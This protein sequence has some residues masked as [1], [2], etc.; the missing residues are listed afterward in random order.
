MTLTKAQRDNIL[1]VLHFRTKD[2][3]YYLVIWDT[4]NFDEYGKCILGYRLNQNGKILFCGEDFHNSP[5]LCIDSDETVKELMGF[6]TLK[7]GDTDKE[8]FNSYTSE[9]LEF[10]KTDAEYLSYEVYERFGWE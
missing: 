4:G 7:P 8:Y 6:L 5:V 2:N 1:R 9:Q 10:A 3:S